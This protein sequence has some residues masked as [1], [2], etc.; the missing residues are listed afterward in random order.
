MKKFAIA[1][2]IVSMVVMD[3]LLS[4]QNVWLGLTLI[5]VAIVVCALID[6]AG[7]EQK[8]PT[9]ITDAARQNRRGQLTSRR[10]SSSA[11]QSWDGWPRCSQEL[12]CAR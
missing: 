7:S 5:A 6:Y 11:H 1:L 8:R 12:Q 10:E 3:M 4:G 2:V 9:S